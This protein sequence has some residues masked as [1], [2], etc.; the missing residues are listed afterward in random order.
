[1]IHL[2]VFKSLQCQMTASEPDFNWK[3][4]FHPSSILR[5]YRGSAS[6]WTYV[7]LMT[8]LKAAF[9]IGGP[10]RRCLT[11]T[12]SSEGASQ[13]HKIMSAASFTFPSLME[14]Q[15]SG[16]ALY[17]KR[18]PLVSHWQVG[19]SSHFDRII[20][21]PSLGSSPSTQR[22]KE[23][24]DLNWTWLPTKFQAYGVSSG[25]QLMATMSAPCLALPFFTLMHR[26]GLAFALMCGP[27]I[28]H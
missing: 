9:S 24:C 11:S 18:S 17:L 28:S 2:K 16:C 8:H 26:P 10:C 19:L 20:S 7:P 13:F 21:S 25:P 1:M 23:G 22:Q 27:S 3:S 15:Y 14:A 5:Q 12:P 6:L 4:G